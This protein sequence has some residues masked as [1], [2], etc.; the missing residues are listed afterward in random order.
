MVLFIQEMKKISIHVP[1]WGTT[2]QYHSLWQGNDYFNPRSRV[3]NDGHY[4]MIRSAE[5]IFQ[6][7]FPRGE[8][9]YWDTFEHH[10]IV[11]S[12]HVPAWGTTYSCPEL[13]AIVCISIHVPAWGTTGD[14]SRVI[15]TW[16]FQST[17]PRGERQ[18]VCF[19]LEYSFLFQSTFP[20]GER[21]ASLIAVQV[22]EN[23]NPRSRVGNDAIF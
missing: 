15:R 1:A 2:I 3:G 18:I 4:Y 12:I 6:S 13:E 23:F 7:T 16:Q 5:I 17:F 14:Q 11:I 20:R 8:R 22:S 21:L 9:R 19:P 10:D